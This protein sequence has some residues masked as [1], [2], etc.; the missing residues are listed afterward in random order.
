MEE[1]EFLSVEQLAA[2]WGTGATTIYNL[3]YRG[4]APPAI[5]IGRELR[6]RLEDVERWERDRRD[7]GGRAA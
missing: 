7:N 2:R 3:R 1:R 4:A 6:F 5:R